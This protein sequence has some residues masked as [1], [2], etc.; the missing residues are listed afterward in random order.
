MNWIACI[1]CCFSINKPGLFDSFLSWDAVGKYRKIVWLVIF[2]SILK[3]ARESVLSSN[4]TWMVKQTYRSNYGI[5]KLMKA[6]FNQNQ[7]SIISKMTAII[8]PCDLIIED[9]SLPM[10]FDYDKS[11]YMLPFSIVDIISLINAWALMTTWLLTNSDSEMLY[12]PAI[13]T[14][15]F[16]IIRRPSLALRRMPLT[17][18]TTRTKYALTSMFFLGNKLLWLRTRLL[19]TPSRNCWIARLALSGRFESLPELVCWHITHCKL[20]IT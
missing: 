20:V 14:Q 1:L 6:Y 8:I 4:L 19:H 10:P 16:S 9:C 13:L 11:K 7:N 12:S 2:S 18:L 3:E 17:T 15:L 5:Q